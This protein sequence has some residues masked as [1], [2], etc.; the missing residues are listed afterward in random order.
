MWV[1]FRDNLGDLC[2]YQTDTI[3]QMLDC[4]KQNH[5]TPIRTFVV[6]AEEGFDKP[7]L[8]HITNLGDGVLVWNLIFESDRPS[9]Y[10]TCGECGFDHSYEYEAAYRIHNSQEKKV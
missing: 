1:S 9:D 2:E 8:G 10:E 7:I 3:A 6:Y 4:L 5:A